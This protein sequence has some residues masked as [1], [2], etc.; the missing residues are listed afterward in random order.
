[1]YKKLWISM[2]IL[3]AMIF[4]FTVCFANDNNMLQD[5]TNGIRN[6]VG[7][8]ENTVE[9]AAKDITNTSKNMTNAVENGTNRTENAVTNHNQMGT[10][11]NYNATRTSTGTTANTFMGMSATAW[12]WLIMGIAA[13][14]IIA[15]V[16]YYSMQMRSTNYDD[17]D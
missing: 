13:I 8:A 10:S 17:K 12:T 6:V 11:N 1:M 3:I 4:S 9:N 7:G 5:A 14:A 16:W 2:A 15:L